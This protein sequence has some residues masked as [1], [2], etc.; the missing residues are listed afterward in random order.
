MAAKADTTPSGPSNAPPS[1]TESR[2]LP[3]AM[4]PGPGRPHQAHRLPLRSQSVRS[5]SAVADLANQPRQ[6]VSA[7]V[8]EY[9][10]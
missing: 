5:P 6:E 8:Q 7:S 10:R 3:V 1:G 9:R 2:W 4:A